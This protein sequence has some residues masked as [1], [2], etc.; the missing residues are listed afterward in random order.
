[1][2]LD[3]SIILQAG[4]GVTPLLSNAEIQDQQMQREGNSLKLNALRQSMADEQSARDIARSTAPEGLAGA[5]YRAGLVKPA[6]EA[7]KFQTDQQKAT[8]EAEKSKLEAAQR[9]FEFV[10]QVMSGVVNQE[11]YDVARRQL[12][13]GLGQEAMA[14]IPPTYDPEAIE[15]NRRQ[16]L[17]VKDQMDQRLR[18][19]TAEETRR[20]NQATEATSAGNL[21]VARGNLEVNRGNL[22]VSTQRLSDYLKAPKG[23]VVQTESGPVIVDTKTATSRPVLDES[24]AP[25]RRPGLLPAGVF[26]SAGCR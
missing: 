16:A 7:Q 22:A 11:T 9:K 14:N 25:A 12:A 2:A 19:L 23:Q 17:S 18:A 3:P 8:R 21:E 10:G 15:R 6:Q 4:R 1:M 20:H 26:G 13:E 24:G 5:Y